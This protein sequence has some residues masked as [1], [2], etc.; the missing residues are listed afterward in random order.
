[1]KDTTTPND[2][3]STFVLDSF[4]MLAKQTPDHL[5]VSLPITFDG[6]SS[7]LYQCAPD[8][9]GHTV[10]P[11]LRACASIRQAVLGVQEK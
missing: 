2:V 8:V 7:G 5:P 6:A 4:A 3:L 10:A 1:M 9:S 11:T